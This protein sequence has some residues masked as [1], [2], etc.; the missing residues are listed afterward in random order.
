MKLPAAFTAIWVWEYHFPPL[1][2]LAVGSST[3]PPST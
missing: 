2:A 3:R 1:V